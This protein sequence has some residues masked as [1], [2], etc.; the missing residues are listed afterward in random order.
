MGRWPHRVNRQ[1]HFTGLSPCCCGSS[2]ACLQHEAH[3]YNENHGEARRR[4]PRSR[5][6]NDD[7]PRER[8]V[9]SPRLRPSTHWPPT[10]GNYRIVNPTVPRHSD[11]NHRVGWNGIQRHESDSNSPSR[12]GIGDRERALSSRGVALSAKL[13][14]PKPTALIRPGPSGLRPSSFK[15]RSK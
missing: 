9:R 1:A 2:T 15:C 6:R 10:F 7:P 13:V 5:T 4:A 3:D 14:E 8:I 12:Q 11:Q